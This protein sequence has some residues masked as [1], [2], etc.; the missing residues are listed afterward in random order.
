[1]FDLADACAPGARCIEEGPIPS[2]D[3]PESGRSKDIGAP[4]AQIVDR[5]DAHST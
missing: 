4:D 1:M 3:S 5:R 2:A